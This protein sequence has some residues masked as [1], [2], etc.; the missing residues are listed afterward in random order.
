M[1]YEL[2]H[3]SLQGARR[4]NQDRVAV[5]EREN[6]VLMVVADGL[7]G[8]KGGAIAAELMTQ[9]AVR[10]FRNIKQ[11]VISQPSAFLAFTI[12][13]AHDQITAYGQEQHPPIKPRTTC[14]LS[15][16][17]NGYAYWA[18]VGDSRLYHYRENRLL[19]R[20]V[21][22]STIERLH[23]SGV[24]S[25]D[26]MLTH[27]QKSAILKCVGGPKPPTISLGKEAVLHTGDALLLCSDGVWDAFSP[28]ELSVYLQRQAL[29]ESIEEL[30][31]DAEAKMQD[32]CDNISAICF[33]W[34]DDVTDSP[35]LQSKLDATVD[36][37]TL[38]EK[39]NKKAITQKARK[40]ATRAPQPSPKNV[41]KKTD[42]KEI[43]STIAELENYLA[44]LPRKR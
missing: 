14:V 10:A 3:Y 17:Q 29:D 6:A 21:D 9:W 37:Q 28:E 25:E 19:K 1:K 33:R 41:E 31:H 18:H 4:S 5:A 40:P 15:L 36:W 16:V 43:K 20:T 32:A 42:K 22:H 8:H 12:L 39:A 27:P 23:Q 7:G 13:Q 34:E 30:L 2:A 11:P 38:W 24:I 44:S 26:E 35:P